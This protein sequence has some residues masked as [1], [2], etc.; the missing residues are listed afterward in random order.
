MRYILRMIKSFKIGNQ[1]VICLP[2]EHQRAQENLF[3]H[4]RAF[5]I[6]LELGNVG[7]ET[8]MR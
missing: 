7:F 8:M 3:K 2:T 6:E 5:Q 4:V 1:N